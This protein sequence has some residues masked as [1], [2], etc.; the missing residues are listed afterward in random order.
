MSRQMHLII[1]S[2]HLLWWTTQ[3][4]QRNVMERWAI[5]MDLWSLV[6]LIVSRFELSHP[7]RSILIHTGVIPLKLVR[8]FLQ[9]AVAVMKFLHKPRLWKSN[10]LVSLVFRE[11][12]IRDGDKHHHSSPPCD[13]LD[14]DTNAHEAL[15]SGDLLEEERCGQRSSSPWDRERRQHLPSRQCDCDQS[16]CKAQGLPGT[17]SSHGC[18]FRL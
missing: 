18:R 11:E 7:K 13:C 6:L 4:G 16:T 14:C 17:L 8:D 9:H 15:S 10:L 3:L 2:T 12:Y 1:L 5:V